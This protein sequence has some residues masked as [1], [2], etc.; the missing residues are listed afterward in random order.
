MKGGSSYNPAPFPH[1][2][3]SPLPHTPL[4]VEPWFISQARPLQ[5]QNQAI[6]QPIRSA[7]RLILSLPRLA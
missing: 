2:L 3:I 5:L 4:I 6:W 1:F 7:A